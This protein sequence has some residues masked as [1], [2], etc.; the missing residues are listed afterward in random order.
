MRLQI[1]HRTTYSY[2][3]PV[4]YALQQI[5]LTP[6]D[7]PSQQVL[8][9]KIH[10]EGGKQELSFEDQNANTVTLMSYE[11]DGHDIVVECSGEVETRDTNGVSGPQGGFAPL[12]LFRRPT[13]LTHQGMGIRSLVK[14][15]TAETENP[16]ERCHLLSAR[17]MDAVK[18]Q[19]GQTG[20]ATTAEEA[21]AA[22]KG[23][24]QDHAH[25]F[26]AAARQLGYA[27]RYVSGYLM[28]DEREQQ[29]A[30]HAW[31]E[32]HIDNLGWVGFDVPNEVCPD[33]R[34]VRIATGRD[35][36]EAAP[37]SGLHFGD[38]AGESLAVSLQVQ[39]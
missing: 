37:I 32:V 10:I 28:M 29:E 13:V 15:L 3:T 20:P 27:A 22:G 4:A 1:R 7:R 14:G 21:L 31:A 18:Y 35:Y 39:Q 34:Y 30:S 16:I 26:I 38:S 8:D 23:V 24:C 33:E 19:T 5:R 12:W 2:S 6:K 11:G 36:A 17:V 25:V 9:W